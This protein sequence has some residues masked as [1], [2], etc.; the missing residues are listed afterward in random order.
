MVTPVSG[1]SLFSSKTAQNPGSILF[2][3]GIHRVSAYQFVVDKPRS[4][5]RDGQ[6]I[7]WVAQLKS[8]LGTAPVTV[9]VLNDKTKQ[10]IYQGQ[11]LQTNPKW[12]QLAA[13]HP[14]D[15]FVKAGSGGTVPGTYRLEY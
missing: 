10:V 6:F 15:A 9:S 8:P 2:G 14:V 5:F 1:C 3:S 12:V 7:G 11:L 13:S 4:T